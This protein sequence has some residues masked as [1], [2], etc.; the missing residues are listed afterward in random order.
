MRQKEGRMSALRDEVSKMRV[1][2]PEDVRQQR[3]LASRV[4]SISNPPHYG[5]GRSASDR[6]Q[7]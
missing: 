6:G 3:S 1:D 7:S 2:R 4:D 5:R